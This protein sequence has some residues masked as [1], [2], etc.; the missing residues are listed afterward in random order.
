MKWK[1]IA[2]TGLFALLSFFACTNNTASNEPAARQEA[3]LELTAEE[4][5]AFLEKGSYITATT[6]SALSGKLRSALQEEGVPGAVAYCNLVAY[7][8]VDSLSQVHQATIR[9]TS[10]KIRNPKDKPTATELAVLE[11]YHANAEKGASLLPGVVA[12]D[13]ST[14]AY[15]APILTQELCLQCHGKIGETLKAEDYTLVKELYPEDEAIGYQ[16]GD[17][18]GMWSVTFRR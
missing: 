16:S 1:T 17:L 11:T 7:P 13:Q 15:Y 8:L 10:L 6:F 2:L 14:V 18:R 5:E 4:R 12:I 9:R 3:P